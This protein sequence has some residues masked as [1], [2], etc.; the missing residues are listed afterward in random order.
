[1]IRAKGPVPAVI[2]EIP[3]SADES[4]AALMERARHLRNLR[5]FSERAAEIGQNHVGKYVC[6]AG[7]ELFVGT[8]AE[9]V[10][11]RAAE[12]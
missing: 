10:L 11:A 6:V 9:E 7:E 1:M 5:W 2:I 4:T 12:S 3:S 8:V